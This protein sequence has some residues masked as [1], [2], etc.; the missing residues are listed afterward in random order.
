[1]NVHR[2]PSSGPADEESPAFEQQV[3]LLSGADIA[4]SLPWARAVLSSTS[5]CRWSRGTACRLT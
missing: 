2:D 4:W 3:A 5:V 1:M